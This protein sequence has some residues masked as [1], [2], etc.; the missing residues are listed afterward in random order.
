[1]RYL[2]EI[3][4]RKKEGDYMDLTVFQYITEVPEVIT[5]EAWYQLAANAYNLGLTAVWLI[6][7]FFT[8]DIIFTVFSKMFKKGRD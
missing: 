7:L 1:M 4:C 8:L 2:L 5:E 6:I 3:C